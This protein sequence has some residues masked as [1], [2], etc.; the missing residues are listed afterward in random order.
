MSNTLG[1]FGNL[2][3]YLYLHSFIT[4]LQISIKYFPIQINI[5]TK[6]QN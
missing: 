4:Q 3:Q 1:I 2:T 5:Y 6:P